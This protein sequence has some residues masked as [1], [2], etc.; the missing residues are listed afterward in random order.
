MRHENYTSFS[1]CKQSRDGTRPGHPFTARLQRPW[2]P[3]VAAGPVCDDLG[4]PRGG[5]VRSQLHRGS[6]FRVSHA[7]LHHTCPGISLLGVPFVPRQENWPLRAL[8][9]RSAGGFVISSEFS[10]RP[11]LKGRVTTR[12]AHR[13]SSNSRK[14][15]G[16]KSNENLK[17]TLLTAGVPYPRASRHR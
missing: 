6:A 4:L 2:R 1:V 14:C 7:P 16:Q 9:R 11:V 10:M 3:R 5:P 13:S 17:Q 15:K 8:E 12:H